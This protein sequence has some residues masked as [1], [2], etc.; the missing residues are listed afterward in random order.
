[1]PIWICHTAF[2]LI[3]VFLIQAV[4]LVIILLLLLARLPTHTDK[5]KCYRPAGT[6]GESSPMRKGVERNSNNYINRNYILYIIFY[7]II[8]YFTILYYIILN[9]YIK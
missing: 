7:Y 8:L 1:M 6:S 9:T 2:M 3:I 4:E 5:A